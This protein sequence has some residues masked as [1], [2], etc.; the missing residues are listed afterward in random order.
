MYFFSHCSSSSCMNKPFAPFHTHISI[1]P[2][3]ISAKLKLFNNFYLFISQN[4]SRFSNLTTVIKFPS[5]Q[6]KLTEFALNNNFTPCA[7]LPPHQV[8]HFSISIEFILHWRDLFFIWF[9]TTRVSKVH[10]LITIEGAQF[11]QQLYTEI[12][13]S[14]EWSVCVIHQIRWSQI[15]LY[16]S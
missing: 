6:K 10:Q 7:W 1:A 14:S 11:H 3:L 13:N 15:R 12:E 5:C 8:A 16:T 2:K 9:H 4:S